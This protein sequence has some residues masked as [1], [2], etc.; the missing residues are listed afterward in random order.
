LVY[1][2]FGKPAEVLKLEEG[3]LSGALA[4]GEVV[5]GLVASPVHPSD[6]GMIS[7]TYGKLPTLPAVG[8]REGLGRI[9]D[10]GASA[11]DLI[12]KL[13]KFP[14]GAWRS[15]AVARA[16]DLFFVPD[17]VDVYQASMAFINPL[18]A[19]MLLNSIR[20]LKP[21][22]WIIQNAANSAVG[23]AVMQIAG[24]MGIRTINLVRNAAARSERLMASGATAVFDEDAFDPKA[25]G[26]HTDGNLPL[27]GFNSIGGDSAM[28]IIK[29]VARGGEVVTFGGMVGDRVR[30][31]TRELIFKDLRLRGFWLDGWASAQSHCKMQAMYAIVFDL[32]RRGTVRIPV[33]ST[34]R[35]SDGPA[36]LISAYEASKDGKVIVVQ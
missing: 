23:V 5:V 4:A 14:F 29:S 34:A 11:G 21:G 8:G 12:G 36:A 31:P 24:A 15:V 9:V 13:V 7:G 33:H 25:L 28:K 20:E 35:L 32:I 6:M 27:L 26:D 10:A 18:T 16:S 1:G 17:G 30:F 19:W 22:D 2:S 3:D